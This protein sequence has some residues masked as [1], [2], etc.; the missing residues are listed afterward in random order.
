MHHREMHYGP[1]KKKPQEKKK[2]ELLVPVKSVLSCLN[3]SQDCSTR[4]CV[5]LQI[6]ATF[7]PLSATTA[8]HI[9]LL[10]GSFARCN[11]T[12]VFGLFLS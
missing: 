9:S 10:F 11:K 5:V 6:L 7:H 3:N 8:S 12:Y 2:G 1:K 4:F